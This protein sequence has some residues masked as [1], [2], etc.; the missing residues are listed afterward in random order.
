MRQRIMALALVV[1]DYEAGIAFYVG[2]L[3]FDLLEDTD[4]ARR[5]VSSSASAP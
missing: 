4:M 5:T 2:K 3:G 1:P